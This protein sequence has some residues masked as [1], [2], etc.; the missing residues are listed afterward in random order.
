MFL[1]VPYPLS[2]TEGARGNNLQQDFYVSVPLTWVLCRRE[3]Y[4]SE[5]ALIPRYSWSLK[6]LSDPDK[7]N[8]QM[9]PKGDC[10]CSDTVLYHKCN[11]Y[12]E[13][14]VET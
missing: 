6:I 7:K 4:G 8:E 14:S 1:L 2:L 5:R 11:T 10:G 12:R 13:M 3:T 9:P